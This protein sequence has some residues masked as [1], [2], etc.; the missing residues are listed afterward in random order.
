MTKFTSYLALFLAIATL[1]GCSTPAIDPFDTYPAKPVTKPVAKADNVIKSDKPTSNVFG[2]AKTEVLPAPTNAFNINPIEST[3][4][5]ILPIIKPIPTWTLE[6]GHTISQDLQVWGDKAD[7]KWKIVWN[8]QKDW[9]IPAPTQFTGTFSTCAAE[10][11]K[12]LSSNGVLIHAQ[13][14][15]G[16]NTMVVTGP[17]VTE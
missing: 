9:T 7:P 5:N 13:F 8:M 6:K 4:F 15:E 16:N 14:F 17:G 3:K 11:I 1:T 12:T 2:I 10:V